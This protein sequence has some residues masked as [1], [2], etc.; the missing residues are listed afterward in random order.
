MTDKLLENV[1]ASLRLEAA[2]LQDAKVKRVFEA[3]A[4]AGETRVVG[5]A[6]RN[7]LL[8]HAVHEVDFATTIPPQEII[9]CARAA[10]LRSV[11]TGVE[12][13]TVTLV[14]DGAPFEVTTTRQDVETDGRRAIVRFGTSFELDAMRRDFT[15]NALS[16]SADGKLHDYT[17]GLE[18]IAA[19]RVRFIGDAGQR[20]REDYLRILRYFRFHSAY[21][22][23]VTDA[24]ARSAI[25]ANR[26]GLRQLSR[27]R[28]RAELLKFLVTTRAG[29]V[30][31]DISDAGIFQ[32]LLRGV[33][34]PARLERVIA[35]EQ[36]HQR[37]PDALLRMI[38]L[39]VM[40]RD[41]AERLR[42]H[43]RLS[44]VE[45]GRADAAAAAL[46]GLHGASEPPQPRQLH[47][48][49]FTQGRVAALDALI[50]AHAESCAAADDIAWR[51][52][53]S[54][55]Q[56]TPEPRMP[57]RGADLMAHGVRSGK[58]MGETLK[59]LQA[60]WIRAG[61]PRDPAVLARL[62]EA[63]TRRSS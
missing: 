13:G 3:L 57:F 19:H 25:L 32:I 39:A 34:Y 41:D 21:G 28:V 49:L 6:V 4:D 62:L 2:F 24:A 7:A 61:F 31:G 36:A 18:D 54:F 9:A 50:L 15:I 43:L 33:A 29:A 40:T 1:R 8:G 27:E 38:A 23:G 53:A 48:L 16:L 51:S 58:E 35:I 17:G 60:A 5:G 14:V 20:I 22:D 26:D 47:T 52:A 37:P 42:Q 46:A 30:T 11:P 59:Q 10:K 44:N 56:D 55:L 63:A 45:T 12:H